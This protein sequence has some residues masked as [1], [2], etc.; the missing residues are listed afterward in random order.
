[1]ATL[2]TDL[3]QSVNAAWTN[4][5]MALGGM[6]SEAVDKIAEEFGL[7]ELVLDLPQEALPDHL[8]DLGVTERR[9]PAAGKA[10]V[11]DDGLPVLLSGGS[12]GGVAA[13][14]VGGFAVPVVIPGMIIAAPIAYMRYRKRHALQVRQDYIRIVREVIAQVRQEFAGEFVL[15]LIEAREGVEVSVDTAITARKK[16]LEAQ[17]QELHTLFK[18]SKAEQQGRRSEA[19]AKLKGIRELRAQANALQQK[20]DAALGGAAPPHPS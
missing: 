14:L 12:L 10:N 2:N 6:L 11:V 19:E 17:R 18:Q 3:E 20:V 1:M 9:D 16:A 15:K 13:S 4:V 5:G 7:E 8:R